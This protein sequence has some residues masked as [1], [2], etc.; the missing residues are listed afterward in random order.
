MNLPNFFIVGAAKAGTTSVY[1]Y[2]AQHPEIFLSP[3]KEPKYLS[4]PANKL[5]H[6]GPGDAKVDN[7]II[8][9]LDDYLN[10]FKN[11]SIE[12]VVGEASADY[13]YFYKTVIPRTKKTNPESKI[14]IM[15]RNPIERAF[16][17]YRHMLKDKRETLSFEKALIT[18]E[19]RKKD[20][21][22]FIWF[23]KDVGLYHEQV[24]AYLNS[25]G[26]N[27]VKVC[28]YDDFI[29]NEGNVIKDILRFLDVNENFPTDTSLKHNVS[30]I[31]RSESFDEFL[32]TYDHPVKKLFRPVFLNTIGKERTEK[33]VNY[34]K[35]KNLL[36]MKPKT[37]KHLIQFYRNDILKLQDL[38]ERDLSDWM[39]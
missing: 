26:A 9:T 18:E 12:K 2:L 29:K 4:L 35:Y 34:F 37:R 33:I 13:L 31:T 32:N 36:R 24:K 11:A 23:Y 38:I 21:Y 39:E 28:L 22:E 27:K 14:L 7:S 10:L 5:P 25:F 6:R 3:L 20:N 30:Q 16:S 17:A 19:Q 15:L 1:A 8:K